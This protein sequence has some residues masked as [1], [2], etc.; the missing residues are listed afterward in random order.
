MFGFERPRGRESSKNTTDC[1]ERL[2]KKA[3]KP[4][5]ERERRKEEK[6]ERTMYGEKNSLATTFLRVSSRQAGRNE[7]GKS[8]FSSV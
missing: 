7:G 5:R 4:E 2:G 3:T 8:P 1:S 6:K